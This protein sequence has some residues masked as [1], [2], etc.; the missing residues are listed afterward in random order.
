MAQASK[1]CPYCNLV[2]TSNQNKVTTTTG[3][4][5]HHECYVNIGIDSMIANIE[6]KYPTLDTKLARIIGQ[7]N[8]LIDASQKQTDK[9]GSINSTLNIFLVIVI[10]GIVISACNALLN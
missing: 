10:V 1:I 2:I 6:K 9:L 4:P 7:N 3:V 8:V 5:Y